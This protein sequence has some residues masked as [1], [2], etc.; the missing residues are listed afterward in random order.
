MKIE[1]NLNSI[2]VGFIF[3]SFF[4]IV[5]FYSSDAFRNLILKNETEQESQPSIVEKYD[6][7]KKA[8]QAELDA[9]SKANRLEYKAESD[10]EGDEFKSN[11]R[12]ALFRNGGAWYSDGSFKSGSLNSCE[13]IINNSDKV[14][15]FY[16]FSEDSMRLRMRVGKLQLIKASQNPH[17]LKALNQLDAVNGV[18]SAEVKFEKLNAI[19]DFVT[20]GKAQ[21]F[22]NRYRYEPKND[23][24]EQYVYTCIS[25]SAEQLSE[26]QNDVDFL[27]FKNGG[28]I[29]YKFCTG[30]VDF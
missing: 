1:L 26:M 21:I 7:D 4:F 17:M 18:V 23:L 28:T 10:A 5:L 8:E 24:F 20:Q 11:I 19:V 25:C 22:Q 9:Y 29:K 3:S 12:E 15:N 16:S 6:L 14:I 30:T 27:P 13:N 2:I